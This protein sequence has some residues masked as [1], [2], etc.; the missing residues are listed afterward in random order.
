[1]YR[2]FHRILPTNI[3]LKKY[4]IKTC[5]RCSFC[6]KEVETYLHLVVE[7]L[8]NELFLINRIEFSVKIIE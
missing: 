7:C 8:M 6:Q 2:V 3:H 5:N 4:K 1:M